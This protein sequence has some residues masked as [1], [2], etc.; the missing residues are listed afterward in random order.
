MPQIT[1]IFPHRLERLLPDREANTTIEHRE[2][3]SPHPVPTTA[4]P[5]ARFKSFNLRVQ[6]A[7]KRR[8]AAEARDETAST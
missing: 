6:S 2:T 3:T 8:R 7:A 4:L 1:D 5:Q